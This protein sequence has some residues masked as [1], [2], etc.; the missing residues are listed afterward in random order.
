M[1]NS[2]SNG[3]FY[4]YAIVDTAPDES[5]F[6]TDTVCPR[7][8]RRTTGEHRVFFSIREYE[9]NISAAPSDTADITVRLQFKCPG[10]SDWTD[11]VPLDGSTFAVGNRVDISEFGS[12]VI[13]RAGVTDVDYTSGSVIFGFDW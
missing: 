7:Y 9:A 8:I 10:D 4:K 13:W 5:G 3:D 12:G 2:T 11:Y 6:F 1:A